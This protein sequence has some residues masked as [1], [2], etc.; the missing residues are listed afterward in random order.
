MIRVDFPEPETPVIQTKLPKGTSTLIF[1]RLFFGN[2]IN[3]VNQ[4]VIDMSDDVAEI[5]QFGTKHS[6]NVSVSVGI[7][8]WDFFT[9]IK[10]NWETYYPVRYK[11]NNCRYF[12]ILHT[13]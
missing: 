3:G 5:P 2:E 9:K 6:F 12:Y 1:F 11:N 4:K 10:T 13:S 7:V 8:I